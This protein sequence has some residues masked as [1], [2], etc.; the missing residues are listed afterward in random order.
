MST[1]PPLPVNTALLPIELVD[2]LDRAYFL[3]VLATDPT[4]VLPPGKSLLSALSGPHASAPTGEPAASLHDRVED[5]VHRAFWD[6]VRAPHPHRLSR[7]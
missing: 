7:F 5:V 1:P 2:I 6:E 4:R 3:H